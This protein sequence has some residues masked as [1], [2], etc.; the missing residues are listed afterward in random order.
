VWLRARKS[1]GAVI[2]EKMPSAM[3]GG[4]LLS[5]ISW[6]KRDVWRSVAWYHEDGEPLLTSA[7][8]G[9]VPLLAETLLLASD[10][11][12]ATSTACRAFNVTDYSLR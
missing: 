7:V 4:A 8:N 1:S 5:P 10:C 6:E 11:D 9:S 3:V 2:D 12:V